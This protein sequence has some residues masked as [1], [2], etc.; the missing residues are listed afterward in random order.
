MTENT[1]RKALL[2]AFDRL[3]ERAVTKL[4]LDCS[5]EEKDEAKQ[6]F[7][8]RYEQA[9]EMLDAAEFPAISESDLKTM[10]SGIDGIPRAR[11]AGYLAAGPLGSHVQEFIQ[12]L[13]VRAAEQRLIEQLAQRADDSYGGN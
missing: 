5:Q 7:V 1:G 13:A 6:Y 4:D 9:L 10:E 2:A 3:F 12:R 11:I 8:D